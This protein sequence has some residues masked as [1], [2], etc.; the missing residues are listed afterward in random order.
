[1]QRT[2]VFLYDDKIDLSN[3]LITEGQITEEYSDEWNDIYIYICR[4]LKSLIISY[5]DH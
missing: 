5:S 4:N 3:F 2:N 1:M